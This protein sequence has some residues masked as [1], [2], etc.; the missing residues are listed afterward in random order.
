M[1]WST[2]C[3]ICIFILFSV[4]FFPTKHF[5]RKSADA[6]ISRKFLI[7]YIFLETN[8]DFIDIFRDDIIP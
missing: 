5:W 6:E 1:Y 7:A 3:N 8:A 2:D 4:T